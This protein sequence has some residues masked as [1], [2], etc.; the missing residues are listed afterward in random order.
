MDY[1]APRK[2]YIYILVTYVIKHTW[3]L[4]IHQLQSTFMLKITMCFTNKDLE[5]WYQI[6]YLDYLIKYFFNLYINPQKLLDPSLKTDF[7]I[8]INRVCHWFLR[9][10]STTFV[11]YR[12]RFKHLRFSFTTVVFDIRK[13]KRF[14]K[15]K[16][17]RKR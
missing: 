7:L 6:S 9:Y 10:F 15:K 8:T 5:N 11:T 14:L 3:N 13:I 1:F 17:I 4:R 16:K 2:K 12:Q